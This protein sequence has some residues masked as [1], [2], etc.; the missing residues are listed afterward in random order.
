MDP[1]SPEPSRSA[2]KREAEDVFDLARE[3]VA[4]SQ[5]NL[6]RVPLDEPL[7]RQV[8][9]C[10]RVTSHIAHRRELMFLAKLLRRDEALPAIRAA[11]EASRED[12]RRDAARQRRLEAWRERLIDE[13][14]AALEALIGRYPDLDRHA[15]RQLVRHARE[16]RLG[17]RDR[18]HQRALFRALRELEAGPSS[19]NGDDQPEASEESRR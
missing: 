3:I 10:R 17:N 18:G 6:A 12:R 1:Q 2:R 7:L 4:L 14:D 16:D 8:A 11:V 9:Q 15:F 5:A 13:G 19:T